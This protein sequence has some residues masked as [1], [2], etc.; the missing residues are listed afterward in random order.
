MEVAGWTL[1]DDK[2]NFSRPVKSVYFGDNAC[3]VSLT[4]KPFFSAIAIWSFSACVD[5]PKSA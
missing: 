3:V 4:V 1:S 5:L 2:A